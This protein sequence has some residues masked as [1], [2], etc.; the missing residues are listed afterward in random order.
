MIKKVYLLWHTYKTNELLTIASLT[1]LDN[2]AYIFK[3]EHE[4]LKA[5]QLGCFLPFNYTEQELYFESLPMFFE[6]RMLKSSFNVEKFGINNN[7]NELSVLTYGDSIKNNDNFR[8]VSEQT[9]YALTNEPQNNFEYSSQNK[10]Y[11]N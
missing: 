8:I 7:Q 10:K 3:Y 5:K 9:Y 4:A 11:K 1:E 2:K 6:Q